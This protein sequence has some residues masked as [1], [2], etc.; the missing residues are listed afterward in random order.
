MARKSVK[1]EELQ[2]WQTVRPVEFSP[3]GPSSSDSQATLVAAR[4]GAGFEVIA[5]QIGHAIAN[6]ASQVLLDFSQTACAIRYQIDGAWESMPPLD[7]ETGDA[8]LYALKQLCYMN[9]ADRRSAQ[10]GE[11]DLKANKEKFD[12]SVRSQGVKT[13]ER[14]LVVVAPKKMPFEKLADLGMRDKM[15]EAFKE[16][17][18]SSSSMMVVSAPKSEGLTT[19]WWVAMNEADKFVRDFQALEDKEKPEPEIIN[20]SA[21]FYGGDTGETETS[22]LS[23]L[24]LREP[25]VLLFPELPQPESLEKTLAQC[26]TAEKQLITRM[27][28]GNAIEAVVRLLAK[29]PQQTAEILKHLRGVTSQKLIRRLCENCK[30]GFEPP[31]KLLAQLGIPAGRVALLYQPFVPPPIEQ[32][33]DE[34]GRP[35][36]I[37]PCHVC[38][39]RGYFG[40]IAVFE[41]LQP[42]PKLRDAFTKTR[43]IAKLYAVAKAEGHKNIQAEAVLTVARGLTGLDELK[44]AFAK[45]S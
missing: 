16:G 4:Q 32:Q 35:A 7:R 13:G 1:Q 20:V 21:N 11:C 14:V 12:I 24:I 39:G 38:N 9:P 3:R 43:D 42:G 28:A 30:V 19:T 26:E 25:D 5:G 31:P 18:N 36:P 2:P 15:I 33:V 10:K 44:R 17:L 23:R 40:R 27:V 45:K 6:R 8:M 37:E 22:L 41:Y 29:Y 34:K